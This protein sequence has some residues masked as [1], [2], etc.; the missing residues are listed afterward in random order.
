MSNGKRNIIVLLFII[1]LDFMGFTLIFPLVPDLLLYYVKHPVYELDKIIIGFFYNLD[2]TIKYYLQFNNEFKEDIVLIIGS[3]V[4]SIY[5]ILQFLFAPY[6]GKQ[7]DL[8][9]R[10]KILILTSSGLAF[11]YLFWFFSKSFSL[12]LFSRIIGGI[13]AGNVGVASAAMA[14]ISDKKKRTAF[15]GLVGMSFGLGFILGPVFGGILYYLGNEYFTFLLKYDF[16]HPF[17]ICSLGSFIL[18]LLSIILNIFFLEETYIP[19]KEFQRKYKGFNIFQLKHLDKR[20]RLLIILNLIYMLIFT[21]YEFT[22]TFFYKFTFSLTPREIGF[23]FFYLGILIALGQGILSRLVSGKIHEKTM[24]RIG[25]LLLP[26]TFLLQP[27]LKQ[28][29]ILSLITLIPLACGN[30]LFQ[31]AI[32][33]Y[34]SLLSKKEEQGYILGLMR[35]LGSLSRAIGPIIGGSLYWL[36]DIQLTYLIF[37]LV[38]VF[39]FMLSYK[40]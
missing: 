8:K 34:A 38:L 24:I 18:A 6:W 25:I 9:G 33:S 7:S 28:N 39:A 31:P 3:I 37:I 5:S 21:S 36:V 23:V 4:S 27:I 11:S 40:L 2:H 29:I 12:F 1:I 14:D 19:Q 16:F 26:F 35:S 32:N 13:M 22:F 17:S 30:S 20:I 15:M 10:K